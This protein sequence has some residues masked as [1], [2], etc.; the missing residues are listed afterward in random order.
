MYESAPL[1]ERQKRFYGMISNIDDNFGRLVSHLKQIGKFENTIIIFTTDNGTAAGISRG[2]DGAIAMGYNSGL[3]GTKGSHYDGGHRVPF[4]M[5]WPKGDILQKTTINEL[6]AHVDLLPTL[7][8]LIGIP[9]NLKKPLDG[10][11]VAKILKG[12][13]KSINRMLVIDT[14]RNQWPEKGRNS[15]VMSTDW[16]LIDGSE[17]YNVIDDPGQGKDVAKEYPEIV[18]KMRK[19]YDDWW[20]SVEPD[21]K[22]AEIPLGNDA[23]NPVLITIHD[24]HT[25]ENLP[26]NQ[27]QIRKGEFYPTGY[28]SVKVEEESEYSFKLYRYP[29]ES[30]LALSATV[31]EIPAMPFRDGLPKGSILDISKAKIQIG[32]V[33]ILADVDP[34]KPFVELKT[35]LSTGSYQLKS[36]F[37]TLKGEEIPSYY[38]QIEKI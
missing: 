23:S 6:T 30:D 13:E 2:K 38:I 34:N 25:A 22:Y 8:D 4:F 18:S 31:D 36:T 26:W 15:C 28:Y 12:E 37:I 35:K 24:M 17:L 33:S 27:V 11:S 9:Y 32:D 5:S 10:T 29:L 14:Q 7:T 3:R 19:F 16:R 1:T 20:A 21:I